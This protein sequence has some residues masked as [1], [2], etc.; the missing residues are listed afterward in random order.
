MENAFLK[1]IKDGDVEKL[2][3]AGVEPSNED[4]KSFAIHGIDAVVFGKL[5]CI[6]G[7]S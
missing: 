7:K 4:L 2:K 6:S 3:K 1:P 5:K